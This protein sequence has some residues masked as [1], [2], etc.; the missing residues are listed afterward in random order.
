MQA[1][2]QATLAF[3]RTRC[4]SLSGKRLVTKIIQ[5]YVT[6]IKAKQRE[7]KYLMGNLPEQRV[8]PTRLFLTCGVDYTGLFFIQKEAIINAYQNIFMHFCLP[9][10]RS[11]S[12]G[13][14]KKKPQHRS[15]HESTRRFISHR[16]KC[17]TILPDNGTHLNYLNYLNYLSGIISFKR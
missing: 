1:G 13:T 15:I 5:T 14:R 16:G 4:L 11:Y 7:T 9:I 3:I 10:K 17:H 12:I 6:W 2:C 8:T